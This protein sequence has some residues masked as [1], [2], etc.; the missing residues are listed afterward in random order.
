M[1]PTYVSPLYLACNHNFLQAMGGTHLST[2]EFSHHLAAM[3]LG[4]VGGV[5]RLTTRSSA[6]DKELHSKCTLWDTTLPISNLGSVIFNICQE[7]FGFGWK[8]YMFHFFLL[9][10]FISERQIHA[11][12]EQVDPSL[13][14]KRLRRSLKKYGSKLCESQPLI[15]AKAYVS[16]N[17]SYVFGKGVCVSKFVVSHASSIE[18]SLGRSAPYIQRLRVPLVKNPKTKRSTLSFHIEAETT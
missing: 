5:F 3:T 2:Q 8:K 6:W 4:K 13:R 7:T 12:F 16:R 1:F 10:S 9:G 15:P 17:V 14:S 18:P 11:S